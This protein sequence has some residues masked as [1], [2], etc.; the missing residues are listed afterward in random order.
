MG[1]ADFIDEFKRDAV[2]QTPKL[3]AAGCAARN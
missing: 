2:A 3:H 1:Q